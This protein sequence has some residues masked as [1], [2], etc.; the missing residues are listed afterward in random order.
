[1]RDGEYKSWYDN[2]QAHV[3]CHYLNGE[4]EGE[5]KSW[6]SSGQLWWHCHYVNGVWEGEHKRWHG[7]GYLLVHDVYVNGDPL[8]IDMDVLSDKDRFELTLR[9]GVNWL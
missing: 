2:G 6:H 5:Y 3:Q 7:N 4:L 1:M 8:D 9:H